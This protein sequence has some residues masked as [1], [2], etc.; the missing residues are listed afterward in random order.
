MN[1]YRITYVSRSYERRNF[2]I[3]AANV[4]QAMQRFYVKVPFNRLIT[5]I[6]AIKDKT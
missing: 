1:T 5:N 3:E 4:K 6:E 2:T